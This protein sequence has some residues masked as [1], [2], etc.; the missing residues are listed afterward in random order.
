MG[1]EGVRS[2]QFDLEREDG[3]TDALTAAHAADHDESV[4]HRQKCS[5]VHRRDLQ[6]AETPPS[7]CGDR[8]TE[9]VGVRLGRLPVVTDTVVVVRI[10]GA[11]GEN[12]PA[13]SARNPGCSH[14]VTCGARVR[15]KPKPLDASP[16]RAVDLASITF[17]RGCEATPVGF[18]DLDCDAIAND[19]R[20]SGDA[21][22]MAE[23]R[24]SRV[25]CGLRPAIVDGVVKLNE[26][27][28]AIVV[29][30]GRMV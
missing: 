29:Q 24:L 16:V 19:D 27:D 11:A 12:D 10:V 20:R 21:A 30:M 1:I 7:S 4:I 23:H 8:V 17:G 28:I 9:D 13:T 26:I 25:R 3:I 5:M 6:T 14:S 18:A 22:C 2:R 15:G